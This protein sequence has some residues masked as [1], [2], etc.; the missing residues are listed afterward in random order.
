MNVIN[1]KFGNRKEIM[2]K[3]IDITKKHIKLFGANDKIK[4]GS[5]K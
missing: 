5:K 2:A 4:E 3:Y 1:H